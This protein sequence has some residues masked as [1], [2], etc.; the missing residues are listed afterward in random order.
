MKYYITLQ[1][2]YYSGTHIKSG[3]S[4]TQ[5]KYTKCIRL[6]THIERDAYHNSILPIIPVVP[7]GI[8]NC[9]ECRQIHYGHPNTRWAHTVGVP[10][11][12]KLQCYIT[13]GC[14]SN[15]LGP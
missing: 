6:R 14:N 8:W 13:V 3:F 4:V 2:H 5:F 11:P 10:G 9:K 12:N 7:K 15:L 1:L